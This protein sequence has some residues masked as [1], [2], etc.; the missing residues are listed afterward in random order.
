MDRLTGL[1]ITNSEN[2]SLIKS[3]SLL[4]EH[5]IET[6]NK[7][8]KLFL[9]E[10]E[11]DLLQ[12]ITDLILR[13]ACGDGDVKLGFGFTDLQI[14]AVDNI[15]IKWD[16]DEVISFSS[17][18]Q[19]ISQEWGTTSFSFPSPFPEKMRNFTDEV[20]AISDLA[21][22]QYSLYIAKLDAEKTKQGELFVMSDL[23]IE[24]FK[25]AA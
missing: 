14:F 24:Q 3:L 13:I 23:K 9:F 6:K 25:V 5:D 8:S 10:L 17:T 21:L 1:A 20:R 11:S 18:I 16:E 2:G 15:D 19:I 22:E 12:L 4:G 7:R